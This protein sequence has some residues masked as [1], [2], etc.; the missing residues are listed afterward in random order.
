MIYNFCSLVCHY[1]Y[2]FVDPSCTPLKLCHGGV[3]VVS[4]SNQ[5]SAGASDGERCQRWRDKGLL[6]RRRQVGV[7]HRR[8]LSGAD[9]LAVPRPAK[10]CALKLNNSATNPESVQNLSGQSSPPSAP[11]SAYAAPSTPKWSLGDNLSRRSETR[12]SG[13]A[14]ASYARRPA[15]GAA[16][17]YRRGAA[18]AAVEFPTKRSKR[19]VRRRANG[20]AR[21]AAGW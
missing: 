10:R 1:R 8:R 21:R 16:S 17:A 7:G 12:A 5:R 3:Q 14:D 2:F 20:P 9:E 6:R 18:N 4:S 19:M 11:S 15:T 13:P